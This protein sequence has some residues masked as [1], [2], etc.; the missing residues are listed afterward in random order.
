MKWSIGKP[1]GDIYNKAYFTYD[2][3]IQSMILYHELDK[4]AE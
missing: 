3:R 1:I 4:A 2:L